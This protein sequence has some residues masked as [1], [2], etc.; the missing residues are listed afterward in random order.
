M[1][2]RAILFFLTLVLDYS[3]GHLLPGLYC[4]E[5]NC[6][7]ILNVTRDS[8]K[9]EISRNYRQLART[10][11]PDMKETGDEEMFKK[12][13]NAYEILKDDEARRDYDYMLGKQIYVQ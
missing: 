1:W 5:E 4:G 8:Q 11:H 12:I 10:Y 9:N 2:R 13:A 3:N 7:D 6:Y